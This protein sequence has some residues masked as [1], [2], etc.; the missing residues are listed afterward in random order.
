MIPRSRYGETILIAGMVIVVGTYFI[1]SAALEADWVRVARD[2]NH[3]IAIDR[4]RIRALRVSAWGIAYEAFEVWY[5][6]D[7]A[8]PRLHND[9]TFNREIV[10]AIVQCDSLW[11]KVI[12]VDMSERN[13]K[14]VARQRTTDGELNDQPWRR[15]ERGATE[16]I[17]AMAACH[18][19]RQ[20]TSHVA[21][22]R[23]K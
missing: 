23:R 5:R 13:G 4:S 21:D 8:L 3:D 10:R 15:V 17:A 14:T 11:F 2:A 9:K 1:V 20:A 16:E 6:T 22:G 18:F 19:G 7:H 12:S